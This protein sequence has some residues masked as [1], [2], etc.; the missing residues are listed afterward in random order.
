[1]SFG[2]RQWYFYALDE[3]LLSESGRVAIGTQRMTA[4]A[5]NAKPAT[6]GG[7]QLPLKNYHAAVK[8]S[9]RYLT[10]LFIPDVSYAPA[11]FQQSVLMHALKI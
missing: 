3:Q 2:S 6:D 10:K 11:M 9:P 8:M 1:M 4:K 5:G 7:L